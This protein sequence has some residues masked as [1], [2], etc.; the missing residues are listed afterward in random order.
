[1]SEKPF[2][3]SAPAFE[4]ILTVIFGSL[5]SQVVTTSAI[6][7]SPST[8]GVTTVA[9]CCASTIVAHVGNTPTSHRTTYSPVL[10]L[11]AVIFPFRTD[12]LALTAAEKPEAP[13]SPL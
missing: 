9:I 13:A 4:N 12:P 8:N 7:A 11:D 10:G 1:M 6:T 3:V 5:A 2:C